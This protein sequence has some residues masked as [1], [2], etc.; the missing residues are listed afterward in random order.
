MIN[1]QSVIFNSFWI[2]GLAT[3][4]AD[5]SYGYWIAKINNLPFRAQI[6]ERGFLIPFWIAV[7]LI[8]IG[9]AG[10]SQ[11]VWESILWLLFTIVSLVFLVNQLRTN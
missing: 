9:L 4:L 1:W 3:L 7:S 2:L 11:Q 5:L 10:T 6:K 8:T